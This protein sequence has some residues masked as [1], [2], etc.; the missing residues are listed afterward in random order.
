MAC[1]H[2]W[3][4]QPSSCVSPLPPLGPGNPGDEHLKWGAGGEEMERKGSESASIL[5][6]LDK[7]GEF[8]WLESG[9]G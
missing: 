9:A 8:W 3:A 6:Q 5:P 2:H 1:T 7:T 4:L